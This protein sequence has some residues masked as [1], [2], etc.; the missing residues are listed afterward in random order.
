MTYGDARASPNND[1]LI[2]AREYYHHQ[3]ISIV[4]CHCF[5]DASTY[6]CYYLY[7]NIWYHVVCIIG[8]VLV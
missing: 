7:I 6:Y 1:A 3:K 4:R 2:G 8:L 5:G